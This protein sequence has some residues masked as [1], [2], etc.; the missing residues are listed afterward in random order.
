M[1]RRVWNGL[2]EF[3]AALQ[4]PFLF[5]IRLYWGYQFA[6]SGWGK[7]HHLQHVV[8]FFDSLGIPFP[9]YN[10]VLVGYVELI[11][12]TLLLLGLCSR[13]AAIPL[14]IS[15]I[16]AYLTAGRDT[17]L[18]IIKYFDPDPFFSASS[19]LF[20]YAVLIIFLFGP[21][22]WSLDYW[23]SGAYKRHEMP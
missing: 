8:G 4:S 13:F 11:G 9:Y 21:G 22:K 10:A 20:G 6:T 14:L 16:V 19:F 23:L 5:I 18:S 1:Y 7:I 3:G 17:L 2:K 15:M 12:G